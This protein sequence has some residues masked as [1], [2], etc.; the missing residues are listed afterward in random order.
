MHLGGIGMTRI[1]LATIILGATVTA[2]LADENDNAYPKTEA[3]L[4]AAY[5]ALHWREGNQNY[6]LPL[7]GSSL[8]LDNNYHVLIGADARRQVFLD[9]G[10]DFPDTEAVVVD[11]KGE[12][13]VEFGFTHDG[14]VQDN[15]WKDIDPTDFLK[16]MQANQVDGNKRRAANGKE[17]LTI[18][19]WLQR[20][21]YDASTHTASWAFELSEKDQHFVNAKALQL[22]REG[23]SELTWIG[24]ME[25]YHA[26]NGQPAMLTDML[27]NHT[28]KLG[29]RYIDFKEGDKVAGYG[30]AALVAGIIG[31]KLGKGLIAAAIA[32]LVIAGKKFGVI[33]ALVAGG[34]ATRFKSLFRRKSK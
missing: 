12:A 5:A 18:V 17:P 1:F 16:Q 2:V 24:S 4:K 26:E 29:S 20:P 7:S 28:Y 14:H 34:A 22:S 19:G 23:F 9:N 10:E 6:D 13:E 8:K 25:S 3:D 31:V 30:I 11:D 33:A 15:D 32:F 21:T 27:G